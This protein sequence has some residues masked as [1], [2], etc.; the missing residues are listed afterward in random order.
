MGDDRGRQVACSD[1]AELE[2]LILLRAGPRALSP[3]LTVHRD[4]TNFFSVDYGDVVILENR[5]YLI[6]NNEREGRFGLDD[7]PKYWVKRAIDLGT[8]RAKVMK[9]GFLEKYRSRVGDIVFDCFR[10]PRKE[11]RILDS[12]R[13]H[14]H[15]M[16][17]F[18]AGDSAGNTVR[19][20]D[21]I[22]GPTLADSVLAMGSNH[23]EYFFQHFPRVFRTYL[24]LVEAIA[25]LHRNGEKHGDIRRDHIIVESRTG[26]P[27]WIDFDFDFTHA[28]SPFQYDLFGLGNILVYL[29]GRG[30]VTLQELRKNGDGRYHSLDEGDVNI[31]FRNR[32]VNLRKIWHYIP[33]DLNMILRHFSVAAEDYYGTIEEYLEDLLEVHLQ[34]SGVRK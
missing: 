23:E 30:D 32:V 17:G 20:I 33:E 6:R 11:A 24:D 21:Y 16:Q 26:S 3:N 25:F 34:L 1:R 12:V 10:S 28:T 29:A 31:V 7:E 27:R 14:P 8:G 15:F 19:I 18:S 9:L 22:R 13:G 2:R 4:T 5:P